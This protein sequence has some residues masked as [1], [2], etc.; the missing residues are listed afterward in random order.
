MV[1]LLFLT[2]L[3]AVSADI[4]LASLKP[5]DVVQLVLQDDS[6]V[7]GGV[8][9]ATADTVEVVDLETQTAQTFSRADLKAIR[10]NLSERQIVDKVGPGPYVAWQLA[11]IFE[12]AARRQ[13]IASIQQAAVYVTA[14]RWSGLMVGDE[15]YVFRLGEPVKDPVTGEI[16]DVPEQK[17]AKLE[18]ISVSDKL[19]TCRPTGEFVVPLHV[20]D[21]IRPVEPRTTVAVLPFMNS[22][23]QPVRSGLK[24]A[25]E[26][27]N[28]LV[29][30]DVPTLERARTAEILGEQL[31]QL[32]GVYEGG[33]TARVGKLLGAA[34]LITGRLID[35][36]DKRRLATL[37]L[38]LLDV[39]TGEILKSMEL[40]LSTRKL[41]MTAVTEFG[42]P[43]ESLMEDGPFAEY[44]GLWVIEYSNKYTHEYAISADG[45]LAFEFGYFPDRTLFLGGDKNNQQSSQLVRRDGAVVAR[46][47]NPLGV[48]V[49]ERF[50]IVGDELRVDRFD[51]ASRYPS[52]PNNRGE[53][54]RR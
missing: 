38:R 13:T 19:V 18:V 5:R 14:N 36:T 54:Q 20:G 40:T 29:N 26:L 53:G 6:S 35:S 15:A 4:D 10:S 23:G 43:G 30:L 27:T 17:V 1:M 52:K 12:N 39:R 22:A 45:S 8:V 41:D 34:T 3:V 9:A 7:L 21:L 28:A 24:I 25:D 51:P 47:R 16:L 37:S 42:Q 31:R 44:Q 11:P 2:S 32:S 50:S 46:L 49:L 33:D 48:E